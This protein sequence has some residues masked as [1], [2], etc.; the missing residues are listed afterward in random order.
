MSIIHKVI[1]DT[2]AKD[3]YIAD[4]RAE[5]YELKQ[6]ERGF[7]ALND[8]LGDAEHRLGLMRDSKFRLS[9][10]MKLTADSD[11]SCIGANQVEIANLEAALNEK[12]ALF[13][14]LERELM[15]LRILS[16]NQTG[17]IN[18]LKTELADKEVAG[19]AIR[20][21]LARFENDLK[22]RDI[23]LGDKQA[24]QLALEKQQ[25]DLQR[26]LASKDL[27]FADRTKQLDDADRE[28]VN[29]DANLGRTQAENGELDKKLNIILVDNDKLRVAND[30]EGAKNDDSSAYLF[31]LESQLREKDNHLSVLHKEADGLKLAYDRSQCTK[32]DLSDQLHA[33]NKHASLLD[34]QNNRLTHELNDI[35]D[36]EAAMVRRALDRKGRLEKITSINEHDKGLSLGVLYDIRSRSPCRKR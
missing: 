29:L 34:D 19:S 5:N 1:V 20:G 27:E 28:V 33:L 26:N 14:Q 22:M 18:V 36:R 4:L 17:E 23:E 11:S 8:R 10:E 15:D 32:Q 13:A 7:Y 9:E 35:A 30:H 6:R 2:E 16:E 12:K 21:D 31:R 25:D 24:R 3:N